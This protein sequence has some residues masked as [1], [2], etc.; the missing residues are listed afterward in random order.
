MIKLTVNSL[1]KM[2]YSGGLK[3]FFACGLALPAWKA[4]RHTAEAC[5]REVIAFEKKRDEL[6]ARYGG[7][8]RPEG[9]GWEFSAPE[10]AKQFGAE[11]EE[12]LRTE[13]EVPGS[14]VRQDDVQTGALTAEDGVSLAPF[15]AD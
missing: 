5:D 8:V 9:N 10:Q 15:F 4:L 3:R 7:K 2:A 14:P 1:V 6:V 12:L 13:I 11:L